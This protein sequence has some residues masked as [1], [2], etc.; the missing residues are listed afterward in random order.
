MEC[1]NVYARIDKFLFVVDIF[2][3]F[4][5]TNF[6]MIKNTFIRVVDQT[7]DK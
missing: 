7:T 3:F 1:R 6:G 5:K 4:E 2:N